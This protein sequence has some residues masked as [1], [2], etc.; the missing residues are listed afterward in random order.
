MKVTNKYRLR[1]E[2]LVVLVTVISQGY[3]SKRI[4]DGD[5]PLVA[6]AEVKVR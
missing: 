5:R 1:R 3:S 4:V 6:W 2:R